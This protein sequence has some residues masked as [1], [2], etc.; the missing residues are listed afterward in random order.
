[1]K[2]WNPSL[3]GVTARRHNLGQ[4]KLLLSLAVNP[5]FTG[6]LFPIRRILQRK[7]FN[8]LCLDA[9]TETPD[10]SNSAGV[11]YYITSAWMA[12]KYCVNGSS[13]KAPWQNLLCLYMHITYTFNKYLAFPTVAFFIA[14]YSFL[15]CS[16]LFMVCSQKSQMTNVLENI[17]CLVAS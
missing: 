10:F 11:C 2:T 9:E 6:I 1:M 3:Q 4:R 15:I 8:Q 5:E 7:I 12:F 17:L 14:L 13:I 16:R